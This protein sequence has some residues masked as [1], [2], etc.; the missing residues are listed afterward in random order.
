MSSCHKSLNEQKMDE[1]CKRLL[2]K[3]QVLALILGNCVPEYMGRSREE[4]CACISDS[5]KI[6]C[7]RVHRMEP[8]N[9]IGENTE[10]ATIDEGTI[11]F[12]VKFTAR[13]A[14]NAEEYIILN[15]EAQ[16]NLHPG[17]PLAK[18]ATYYA[19]RLL[20]AQKKTVWEHSDYHRQQKVYSIWVF[21]KPDKNRKGFINLY[22]PCE[23]QLYGDYT[24]DEKKYS[25][26]NFIFLGLSENDNEN[27]M[28]DLL[29]TYFSDNTP[30][31]KRADTLIKIGIPKEEAIKE[32]DTMCHYSQ[33]IKNEALA[34]GEA[35]GR[36]EGE[37]KGRAEGRAEAHAKTLRTVMA[38]MHIELDEAMDFL[39]IPVADRATIKNVVNAMTADG[40]E[41]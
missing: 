8:E 39:N 34:E 41:A 24:L 25:D 15:I 13:S 10:D 23:K 9:I 16:N 2:G 32:A 20:S 21:L 18:R 3:K 27:E 17:Y 26:F 40:E 1:N 11:Y 22:K 36:A 19:A 31:E 4:I 6:N 12:D 35:K 7:E 30:R 5:V 38:K 14:E 28:I 37:A 33:L 29:S